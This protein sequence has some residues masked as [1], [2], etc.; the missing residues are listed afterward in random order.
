MTLAAA[1]LASGAAAFGASADTIAPAHAGTPAPAAVQSPVPAPEPVRR[2]HNDAVAEAAHTPTE[3]DLAAAQAASRFYEVLM[4]ELTAY[5]GDY[6]SALA[7][8]LE[9]ARQTSPHPDAQRLYHRAAELA[10]QSRSGQR[11]LMV[12]REWQQTYPDSR[13]ANRYLLRVLLLLNRVADTAEPLAREITATPPE[14]KLALYLTLTQLYHRA[15]DQALAA[16]VIAKALRPDLQNPVTAP[17]AWATLGHIHLQADQPDRAQQA[18]EHSHRFAAYNAA[19]A[20]L[21]LD[22]MKYGAT[23]TSAY[24]GTHD[25]AR[26]ADPA[27]IQPEDIITS[28][29]DREGASFAAPHTRTPE[30]QDG[31][32]QEDGAAFASDAVAAD[33]AAPTPRSADVLRLGYAQLLLH[34]G[35]LEKARHQLH[36]L[37][38][39]VPGMAEVRLELARLH[40]QYADWQAALTEVRHYLRAAEQEPADTR[41]AHMLAPAWL[42]GAR[43]A[44][45]TG[46]AEQATRWLEHL[47]GQEHAL[48]VASLK[49]QLLARQ[50]HL[51]AA[52]AVIQAV[53]ARTPEETLGKQLAHIQLLRDSGSISAAYQLQRRLHQQDP[54]D[55]DLAY[56]TALLAEQAGHL[57]EMERILRNIIATQTDHHHAYNALGYA[58][59]QRGQRLHEAR[60][61]IDT[62]LHYAPDDPHIIDSL[63]WLEYRAG[64]HD[65]AVQLLQQAY[66]LRHDVEIA[67]HLGEVLWVRGDKE[68]ALSIWQ[69]ARQRDAANPV[70]RETLLR[71]QVPH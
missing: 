27:P 2:A 11:A 15:S 6:T 35:H 47:S 9:A 49:A 24:N 29:L 64:N 4:G 20:L 17:T 45:H 36:T 50:G 14:S 57:R 1:L 70:L 55:P 22:L 52:R 41:R 7:L 42:L 46:E 28:Y 67:T 37:L 25:S 21:A 51:A 53:P 5:Q 44:I 58:L 65:L 54:D 30:T 32:A 68:R 63:G 16:A 33:T 10:L 40:A 43:A 38:R 66:D 31:T 3:A 8:L 26:V 18:L 61:L 39:T 34:K 13:D 59:A 56:D 69:Q 12:A 23:Y 19:A 71:L 60:Q 48:S 62:A